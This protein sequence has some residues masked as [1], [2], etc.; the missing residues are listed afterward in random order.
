[1]LMR[2]LLLLGAIAFWTGGGQVAW[3][4]CGDYLHGHKPAP[5]FTLDDLPA[6]SSMLPTRPLQ[7][8]PDPICRGPQCQRHPP[9]PAAPS[10]AVKPG[11]FSD[12]IVSA[13]ASVEIRAADPLRLALR[14]TMAIVGPADR[15]FR[16]PRAR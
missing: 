10:K 9:L 14:S 6:D 7:H 8:Q 16:P 4:T 3:A 15:I 13:I 1:M 2:G 11:A 12:A 5:S